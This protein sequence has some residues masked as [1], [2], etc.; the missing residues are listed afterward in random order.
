[1]AKKAYKNKKIRRE[2]MLDYLGNPDNP[3]VNR[4]ELAS[5]ILGYKNPKTLYRLF[6]PAELSQIEA[7][8][9][10][11]RRTK[12]APALSKVDLALLKEAEA[13]N[14]A[15]TKLVYQKFENWSERK[16]TELTG[17]LG[18]DI[19]EIP[20]VFVEADH[21]KDEFETA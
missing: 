14:V 21:K 2:Q 16:S 15:A 3:F 8:G 20:I 19:K 12:Y 6:T 5:Q 7:E 1:M 4:T 9:L 18:L 13:G 10:A 11:I 17:D